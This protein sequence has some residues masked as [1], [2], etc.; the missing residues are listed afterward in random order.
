MKARTLALTAWCLPF[1]HAWGA[2]P[3]AAPAL[4]KRPLPA[5]VIGSLV[6]ANHGGATFYE[7]D[8]VSESEIAEITDWLNA[9]DTATGSFRI[10]PA[11]NRVILAWQR[12]GQP[13]TPADGLI[14]LVV[15]YDQFAGRF[16]HR[17]DRIEIE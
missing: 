7:Q 13:L 8:Y 16:S 15:E 9:P 12:D 14:Q 10:D 6:R 4:L 3:T 1:A 11:K 2:E 17:S 5:S